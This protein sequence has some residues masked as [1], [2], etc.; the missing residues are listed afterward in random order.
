M[1][2]LN[3]GQDMA[4]KKESK[5]IAAHI[6]ANSYKY[7]LQLAAGMLRCGSLLDIQPLWLDGN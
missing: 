3:F 7:T 1:A 2:N 5:N 4:N 6:V